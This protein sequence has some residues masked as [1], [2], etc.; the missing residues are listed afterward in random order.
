MEGRLEIRASADGRGH[1]SLDC[2]VRDSTNGNALRFSLALD[3]TELPD[4]IATLE[5]IASALDA[6]GVH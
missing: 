4:V 6:V 2:T 1:L 3:Q 5:T